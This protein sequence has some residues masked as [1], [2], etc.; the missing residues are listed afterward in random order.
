MTTERWTDDRWARAAL[1]RLVEPGDKA[2]HGML[3]GH[4]PVETLRR[5]QSAQGA[6]ARFAER[7]RR[8]DVQRDVAVAEKVGARLVVPGDG[9]W[10]AGLEDLPVPPW[11]L[12]V[13]GAARLDEVVRRSVAVV[14]ARA[15]SSYGETQAAE[16]AA[17]LATAG[18][19][20]VS[21]AAYGIDG[22]A[23]RGALAVDGLTVAVVASGVDRVY[24]AAH[25]TLLRRISATG[26]IVSEVA[27]GSAP[28]GSRF[29]ARNR[30]IAALTAGTVVVEAG[31]RSGSLQT[32]N[33]AL[34]LNRP[35]GA[36]P[37]PVTSMTSA[38]CHNAIRN[39]GAVLVTSAAEVIE[40]VGRVG[41]GALDEPRGPVLPADDLDPDDARVH[42]TLPRSGGLDLDAL[43][44]ATALTPMVV[45]AALA[46]LEE[47]GL[48]VKKDGRWRK[49]ASGRT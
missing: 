7:V 40:L 44:S 45:L 23:H 26:C 27:P 38:G 15:A 21:G 29:L 47:G 3:A 19:S 9:E 17:G 5:I 39:R 33:R 18:W 2:V 10:P 4:G 35:V 20:V 30:L 34:D 13:R 24:P 28:M 36:V 41:E 46:R 49:I 42:E 22:A 12:W 11:C 1:S 16:L 37:G 32:L 6:L 8:L 25:A 48:A 31:L 14:G 43:L